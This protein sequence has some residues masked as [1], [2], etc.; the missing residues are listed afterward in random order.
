[1]YLDFAE[2]EMI[3]MSFSTLP[4]EVK[5]KILVEHWKLWRVGWGDSEISP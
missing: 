5:L 2:K 4:V 1:M 3:K